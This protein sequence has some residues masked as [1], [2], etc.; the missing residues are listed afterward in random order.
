MEEPTEQGSVT[1]WLRQLGKEHDTLAQQQLFERYFRQLVS[2]ARNRLLHPSRLSRDA[3][4]VA[5]SALGSFFGRF[6]HGD[7]SQLQQRSQLWALLVTIT[8]RKAINRAHHQLAAKRGSG[9]EHCESDLPEAHSPEFPSIFQ[10]MASE[11]PTPEMVTQ[12]TEEC[13]RRLDGLP[14]PRLQEIARL[15]LEGYTNSE[16][17]AELGIAPRTVGR[18]LYRIRREWLEARES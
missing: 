3:E 1:Q 5:L 4:D 13:R 7:C 9:R 12:L 15:K 14:D 11:Q 10:G 17:A 16:I 8:T 6:Q 2:L 18:K